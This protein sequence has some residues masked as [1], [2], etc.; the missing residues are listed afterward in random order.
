[1]PLGPISWTS[2]QAS[3]IPKK[4]AQ[5]RPEQL[6]Y[7]SVSTSAEIDFRL[8]CARALS[9][10]Y[11]S[12]GTF[13]T[14]NSSALLVAY[15]G[16]MKREPQVGDEQRRLLIANIARGVVTRYADVNG[17]LRDGYKPFQPT[18]RMG[19]G[20]H[21]TNYGYSRH[22]HWRTSVVGRATCAWPS[23]LGR[24]RNSGRAGAFTPKRHAM[25]RMDYG[26]PWC[27]VG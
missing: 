11:R 21:Y 16:L 24:R 5:L 13:S 3:Q 26:Y 7:G 25:R 8:P 14:S 18:A 19:E 23:S 20:V 17:A 10:S 4:I 27:S 6:R 9:A 22:E 2:V 15:S 12:S 1:M